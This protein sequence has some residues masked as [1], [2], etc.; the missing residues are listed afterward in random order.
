MA[1][2]ADAAFV[3]ERTRLVAE[4]AQEIDAVA[5]GLQ[6]LNANLAALVERGREIDAMAQLWTTFHARI[7]EHHTAA[8]AAAASTTAGVLHG[9]RPVL[10]TGGPAA[11]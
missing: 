9:Q 6:T 11:S 10:P 1:D 5:Q 4:T 3:Q 7:V 8:S 2:A